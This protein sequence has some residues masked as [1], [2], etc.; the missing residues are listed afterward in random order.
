MVAPNSNDVTTVVRF[1][2]RDKPSDMASVN[3]LE[4]VGDQAR[5]KNYSV[6]DQWRFLLLPLCISSANEIL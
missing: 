3:A 4:Q 1:F 6:L 2:H 5:L